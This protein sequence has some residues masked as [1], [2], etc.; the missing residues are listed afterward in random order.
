MRWSRRGEAFLCESLTPDLAADRD[1]RLGWMMRHGLPW[2]VLNGQLIPK[3]GR[4]V[5]HAL[6]HDEKVAGMLREAM[7]LGRPEWK[8]RMRALEAA[9]VAIGAEGTYG[10]LGAYPLE[11]ELA[12]VN[13]AAAEVGLLT[14][15]NTALYMPIPARSILAP[16]A[17]RFVVAGRVTTTATAANLSWTPRLG[18]ANTSP[19]LGASAATAKTVSI[20]N[21]Y[22]AMKGDITVQRVGI[23][24]TNSTAMGH[25][26]MKLN[27]ASGGAYTSWLWGSSAAASFDSTLGPGNAN[28][29]SLWL[30]MTASAAAADPFIVGQVHW[31]D[32]N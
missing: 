28:G 3:G 15:A 4:E 8:P 1:E 32:W 18:N 2:S 14:A 21:A 7:Q 26:D 30:G 23:A 24:G 5:E 12:A 19:S 22:F 16:Q 6:G 13:T 11:A 20:T 17:W 25:F 9:G 31:M 27:S 10:A 29:G